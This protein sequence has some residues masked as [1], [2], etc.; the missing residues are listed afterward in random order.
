MNKTVIAGAIGECVH[1]AGVINFLRLAETAGWKTVFLGPAVSIAD[2]SSAIK[3][4]H[5]DLV[6]VSYRLTP[7]N[8]ER[9]L[10]DFAES[11]DQ[12]KEQGVRF[13]FG[14]TPPVVKQIRNLDFFEKLFDGNQTDDE[15][16]TFLKGEK[17]TQKE[18]VKYP[19]ETISR[20][21]WKSPFP[22]I[23][24]HFGL[25]TL[26][27]TV[28]GIEQIA[29]SGVL[30][31]I[32]LG[33]DQDAQEN[34]YHPE[35]QNPQRSG[36]GG[37]PV[38]SE[39]DY[40]QLYA[41]SRRGNF[42]L[43]RT[44][45][46]TTDF[47]RLAEMYQRT[48]HNCWAAVPLFWFNQMDKRGPW[49]LEG[50]ITQHQDLIRWYAERGIPVELNE[51]HHWGMRDAPDVVYV[52]AAYLAA[53]NAHALG[54]HDYIAQFMFN[55]PSGTT[56]EMDLAKM[57]AIMDLIQTLESDQFR[58]WRQTRTGLLSYPSNLSAARAHLATSIY[59]Q[60][61]LKP[62]IVHVVS[63][64]EADHIADP[65]DVIEACVMAH[66][67]ISTVLKG[68]P[69]LTTEKRIEVRRKHL[70]KEAKTTLQAIRSLASSRLK[71]PLTSPSVLTK[72]VRLGILDAPH[73]KNN[74]FAKGQIETFIINGGCDAI[75]RNG[76]IITENERLD[77]L[78]KEKE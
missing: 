35:L 47:L 1:I 25:P 34:F 55:S 68:Q 62:H 65:Q 10:A 63:H 52:V 8:G 22:V 49:D 14:G 70:V 43:M 40:E 72:A 3:Q 78:I 28:R 58:I 24:H 61:S 30:D 66:K 2:F 57:L 19:Q 26:V 33:I 67:V 46:G 18:V 36:A 51:A 39:G 56:D 31:V 13:V 48:I 73:L 5:P 15:V 44:Y 6:G 75:N 64:V 27:Q 7:E 16:L 50:S 9:L 60:M 77:D 11:A 54:V 29:N 23:R 53:Y 21:Q 59:V 12:F 42:P 20:L 69:F 71:D 4:Y 74:P 41:A 38:R 45:S 76:K 37:V 32:S 17:V